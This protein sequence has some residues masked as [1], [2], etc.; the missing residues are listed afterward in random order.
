M[1]K[2]YCV[3]FLCFYLAFTGNEFTSEFI[4]IA[5]LVMSLAEN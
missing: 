1:I 4:G 2:K 3:L 5:F